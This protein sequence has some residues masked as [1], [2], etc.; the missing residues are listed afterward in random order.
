MQSFFDNKK[1]GCI[2]NGAHTQIH[3]YHASFSAASALLEYTHHVYYNNYICVYICVCVYT[4]VC[5]Y[6]YIMGVYITPPG[7]ASAKE[8]TCN[9]GD[10][11]D[12]GS[13]PGLRR[14]PGEGH[15]NPL[16]D[17]CLDN[18]VDRGA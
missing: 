7:G 14:F 4:Y 11:R 15:G 8:T 10:V 3:I 2:K 18:P 12:T 13:V 16:Q 17:S 5:V 6:I 9:A 1:R